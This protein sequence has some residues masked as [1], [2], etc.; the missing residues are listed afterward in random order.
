MC[1]YDLVNLINLGLSNDSINNT[2]YK[3]TIN[4]LLQEAAGNL[5]GGGP[6]SYENSTFL[7]FQILCHIYY[8]DI[9]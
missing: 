6:F 3:Y 2:Y 1:S 9:P 4:L 7:C 8:T 5:P